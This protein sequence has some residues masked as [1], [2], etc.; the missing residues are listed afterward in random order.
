MDPSPLSQSHCLPLWDWPAAQL[1]SPLV[2]GLDLLGVQVLE[3][4]G[5]VIDAPDAG[6]L[7]S[8]LQG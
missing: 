1:L 3:L 8:V 6:V 4:H 2:D 5:Q 7:H